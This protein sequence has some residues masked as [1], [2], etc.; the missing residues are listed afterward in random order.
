M[1]NIGLRAHDLGRH[2]ARELARRT[3]SYGFSHIQLALKKALPGF[4]SDIQLSP[5]LARSI[6][7]DLAAEGVRPSI[8]GCY[9]NPVHPDREVRRA[10]LLNFEN[11]IR[12]CRDFG[13]SIVATETGSLNPDNSW[14]PD[15]ASDETFSLFV[16]SVRQLVKVAEGF[17]CHVGIEGVA[18]KNVI[19]RLEDMARLLEEIDSPNLGVV[20]DP[21]N[22]LSNEQCAEPQR[23]IERAFALFGHKIIAI[24][25]KDFCL[26]EGIKNGGLP[27]GQG[28]MDHQWFFSE[29]ERRYA[30]IHVLLENNTPQSLPKTLEYLKEIEVI[31]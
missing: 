21:V 22:F 13:C 31:P 23:H 26:E 30:Q 29:L 6:A 7:D 2:Q 24:H 12:F 16:T 15:N 1:I 14:N 18:H 28:Q 9:I 17:G 4:D 10:G 19:H 3:K 8:L 20:Y 27:L 25:V 5:G 11:H